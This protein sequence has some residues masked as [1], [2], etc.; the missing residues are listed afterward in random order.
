[1]GR[2]TYDNGAVATLQAPAE[3]ASFRISLNNVAP[4]S[5][6]GVYITSHRPVYTYQ[7]R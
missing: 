6:S 5:V 1:M 7:T 2:L 3:G 4:K